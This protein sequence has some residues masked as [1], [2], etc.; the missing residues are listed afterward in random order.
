[1]RC[2]ANTARCT[3][4]ETRLIGRQPRPSRASRPSTQNSGFFYFNADNQTA[5]ETLGWPQRSIRVS[6]RLA[7]VRPEYHGGYDGGSESQFQAQKGVPVVSR[8][9]LKVNG[10]SHTLD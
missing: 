6:E 1:M 8:I 7:N 3:P 9:E 2:C 5:I 4:R 10:R